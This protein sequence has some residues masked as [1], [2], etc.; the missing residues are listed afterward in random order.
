VDVKEELRSRWGCPGVLG[1]AL[2]LLGIGH[3]LTHTGRFHWQLVLKNYRAF[4]YACVGLWDDEVVSAFDLE[5]LVIALVLLGRDELVDREEDGVAKGVGT[6]KSEPD[7]ISVEGSPMVDPIL[8]D[9]A[10]RIDQSSSKKHSLK[11]LIEKF[12]RSSLLETVHDSSDD[13]SVTHPQGTSE[14]NRK[15]EYTVVSQSRKA[16]IAGSKHLTI[17]EREIVSSI[18]AILPV[19]ISEMICCRVLLFQIVPFGVIL[20]AFFS[21][22][23]STPLFVRNKFLL[24]YLPSM[25]VIGRENRELAIAREMNM[26]AMT[27]KEEE[28]IL[29]KNYFWRVYLRGI[30]IFWQ[31]SRLITIFFHIIKLILVFLLLLYRRKYLIFIT[32][33]F[34]LLLPLFF[35]FGLEFILYVGRYMDIN[36][37]DLS[38]W[39][40]LYE[41]NKF[42]ELEWRR[43]RDRNRKWKQRY[44][45][46][47]EDLM[48]LQGKAE[49]GPNNWKERFHEQKE[50]FQNLEEKY[51]ALL[52]L[53]EAQYSP[54]SLER[55]IEKARSNKQQEAKKIDFESDNDTEDFQGL[56]DRVNRRD[57]AEEDKEEDDDG[58]SGYK[59]AQDAPEF[60]FD[61][62]YH[63]HHHRQQE[64]EGGEEGTNIDEDDNKFESDENPL[65]RRI[66]TRNTAAN[67]VPRRTPSRRSRNNQN[68]NNNN[69]NNNN[70]KDGPG[71]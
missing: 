40:W 33:C 9:S 34:F 18:Q 16:Q 28:L 69:K 22:I 61:E 5:N 21:S 30:I 42:Q 19:L 35:S 49:E 20:T 45:E 38:A 41:V 7:S 1:L 55:D 12:A 27:T 3:V 8:A 4:V 71:L 52:V 36:D 29:L 50:A 6:K 62:V 48:K 47:K 60:S 2:G 32:I 13:E 58:Y 43:L 63:H 10:S 31:D 66:I 68:H 26:S 54:S 51:E 56:R 64:V 37:T 46:H 70:H 57:N 23:S 14:D 15:N 59:S 67:Q 53:L 11:E 39:H 24:Q 17:K 44:Y 65:N 25:L